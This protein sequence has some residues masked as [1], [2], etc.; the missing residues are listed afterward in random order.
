MFVVSVRIVIV[1]VWF[2]P[3]P[4]NYCC[5]SSICCSPLSPAPLEH[6]G[7]LY[8]T[9]A[10]L[11]RYCWHWSKASGPS[12]VWPHGVPNPGIFD[13]TVCRWRWMLRWSLLFLIVGSRWRG[14]VDGWR[15]GRVPIRWNHTSRRLIGPTPLSTKVWYVDNAAPSRLRTIIVTN[16]SVTNNMIIV[17]LNSTVTMINELLLSI[18][19]SVSLRSCAFV[20]IRLCSLIWLW[21]GSSTDSHRVN[22]I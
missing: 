13:S 21:A 20:W 18:W 2:V 3:H 16:V 19:L 4:W 17:V 14:W 6:S 9:F 15:C 11:H 22:C 8:S 12:A 1:V 5:F 7:H 10:K